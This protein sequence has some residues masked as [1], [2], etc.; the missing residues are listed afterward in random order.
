MRATPTREWGS[1][2]AGYRTPPRGA[3]AIVDARRRLGMIGAPDAFRVRAAAH[4][5]DREA[6]DRAAVKAR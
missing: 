6:S 1:T 5:A 4:G 2:R 3:R